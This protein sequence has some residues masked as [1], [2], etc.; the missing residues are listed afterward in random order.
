MVPNLDETKDRRRVRCPLTDEVM[1]RLL[2]VAEPRRRRAWYMAA[3]IAG[4]RKGDLQGLT[5]AD[6]D[7]EANTITIGGGKSNRED[8]I[9]MHPQLTAE[10]KRQ[11]NEIMAT[12]KAKV[13]PQTVTDLT[14]QKDFL[15]AGIA[16]EE[17]VIGAD[18][19]P[20]MV[21]KGK[22][23]RP[24]TRIVA[25]DAEGRVYDLHAMRTT[26]GTN[27]ARAGVA[28]QIAQRIMRHADYRT[29][30]KHYTVLGLTD[31][32]KAISQLPSIQGPQRTLATGTDEGP[33]DPQ[34]IPQQL[35]HET[36]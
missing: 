26:L 36:V 25:Q 27:L 20:V 13:F 9:P 6:V 35:Q 7:F 16:R 34:Q 23:R 33:T 30:L 17:A 21:G 8:V 18:G 29:T 32:A 11:R 28:P 12:P 15:R 2:A 1:A 14:R 5:W 24:K 19:K 3:A 31:T 22:R 10:L 4:L